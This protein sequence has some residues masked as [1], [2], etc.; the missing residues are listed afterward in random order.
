MSVLRLF[1]A[2]EVRGLSGQNLVAY[3]LI[4]VILGTLRPCLFVYSIVILVAQGVAVANI[5]LQVSV[6]LGQQL[7]AQLPCHVW[8]QVRHI[9]LCRRQQC[10]SCSVHS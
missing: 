3:A 1:E 8:N 2:I 4:S 10:Q 9:I 7:A 5:V 6:D